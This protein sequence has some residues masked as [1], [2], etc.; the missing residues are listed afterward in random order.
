MGF[1][2]D[3]RGVIIREKRLVALSTLANSVGIFIAGATGIADD[4]RMLKA[5]IMCNIDGLTAGEGRGLE[6]YLCDGDLSV[7][8]AASAITVV[9]PLDAND[10]VAAGIAERPVFPI[11]PIVMYDNAATRGYFVG[12]NGGPMIEQMV[13]WTFATTKSWNWMVFNATGANLTT[14]GIARITTKVFGVWIR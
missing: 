1:G 14:G 8:E 4:F 10:V 6:L 2:K 7:A 3:G 11:G 9:G 12:L 13:R 5:M